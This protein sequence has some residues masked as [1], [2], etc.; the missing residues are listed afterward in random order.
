MKKLENFGGLI[1]NETFKTNR[2]TKDEKDTCVLELKL[3]DSIKFI[4]NSVF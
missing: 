2:M 4:D 3:V 1:Q